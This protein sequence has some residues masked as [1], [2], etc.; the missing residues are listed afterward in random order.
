MK[1]FLDSAKMDEIQKAY[2]LFRIDGITTN[3][4]HI[5]LSGKPF[6]SVIK[7]IGAWASQ[8]GFKSWE[9]F[10]ISVEVNP[11]YNTAKEM[12]DMGKSLADL[13]S[14]FVI[15]LPCTYAGIEAAHKLEETGIRTNLTLVFSV[16]QALYAAH[17]GSLF[18]SPFVGWKESNGEDTRDYIE[19]I[20]ETYANAGATTQVLVAALR[21][22][23]QIAHAFRNGADAVTCG[24]S[25]YEESMLHP[26]TDKGLGIFT[27]AWDGTDT[28]TK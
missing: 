21:S 22:G 17:A 27:D 18:V 20:V 10:P 11:H 5:Q 2:E 8:Q 23:S 14:T 1:F 26:F 3:P 19:G 15:K 7:E 4:R 28:T 16:S 6:Y 12:I 24:L 13:S 25:V 9:E